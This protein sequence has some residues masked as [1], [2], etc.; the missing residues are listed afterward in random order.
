MQYLGLPAFWYFI[1]SFTFES[2]LFILVWRAQLDQRVMFDE[3]Y[4]RRRLT[5]FYILFYVLCFTA[6]IFQS[7]L[8]YN[9]WAILLFNSTLWIPQIIHTY[10]R[11]S[12]KGPTMQFGVALFATQSFMPLYLKTD[13]DNFLDQETDRVAVMFIVLFMA[14]QLFIIKR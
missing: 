13:T 4:M 11:R 3:Q 8:L 2:R 14:L 12:R 9:N 5:W 6:V 10:I 1:S 7:A